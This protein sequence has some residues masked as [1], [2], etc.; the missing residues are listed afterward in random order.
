[1]TTAWQGLGRASRVSPPASGPSRGRPEL[2]PF[3][4]RLPAAFVEFEDVRDA[5]DAIR[6]LNGFNGWKVEMS[7]GPRRDQAGFGGRDRR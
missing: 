6:K 7:R 4:T 2:V 3:P 5:E 1:M